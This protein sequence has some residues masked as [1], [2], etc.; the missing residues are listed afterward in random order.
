[1]VELDGGT[2]NVYDGIVWMLSVLIYSSLIMHEKF[3]HHHMGVL[4]NVG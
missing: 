4:W 3:Y 1:M 2:V